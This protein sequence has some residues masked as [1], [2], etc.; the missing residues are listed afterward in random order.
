MGIYKN[1]VNKYFVNNIF[2]EHMFSSVLFCLSDETVVPNF[3]RPP[4]IN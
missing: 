4:E 1:I 2:E 3:S